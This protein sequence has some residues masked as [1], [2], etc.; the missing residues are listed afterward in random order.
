MTDGRD[1]PLDPAELDPDPVRQ[2][3]RWLAEARAA[4]IELAEAAALATASADGAP[5]ARMVLLKDATDAGLTFYTGYWSRKGRELAENPRAAL[6]LYW[7]VFGR[8]VRAEGAVERVTTEESD[9]YFESRPLGSRLSA[10]VS[11][12]SEVI[13]RRE[14]LEHAAAQ[15]G[16]TR[17]EG[18]PRPQ[19]WGGYRLRPVLW[20]FWQHRADRLHDRFRY[21]PGDAGWIVERLAP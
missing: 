21:R 7:H 18:V 15:L 11:P 5:S 10:A 4:G 13:E 9:E 20:E 2:L 6:L 1:R 17:G 8:Q 16:R 12:Q 14:E 19:H 3:D